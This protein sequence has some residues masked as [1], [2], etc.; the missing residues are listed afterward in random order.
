MGEARMGEAL[1][2]RGTPGLGEVGGGL[3]ARSR[4]YS[5]PHVPVAFGVFYKIPQVSV[6]FR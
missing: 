6:V 5:R 4:P 2:G 1:A 3:W